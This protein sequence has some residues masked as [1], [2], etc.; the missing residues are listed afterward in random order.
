MRSSLKKRWAEQE[1]TKEFVPARGGK[2]DDLNKVQ[3]RE[4]LAK[5]ENGSL[6]CWTARDKDSTKTTNGRF[7]GQAGPTIPT[8]VRESG[9]ADFRSLLEVAWLWLAS[10][11][12][13]GRCLPAFF[14][15]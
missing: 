8:E 15:L 1:K 3:D 13:F 14:R 7:S 11:G 12:R 2:H 9:L 6:R 5:A 10:S 4:L